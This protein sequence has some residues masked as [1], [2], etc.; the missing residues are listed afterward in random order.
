MKFKQ[1]IEWPIQADNNET[2]YFDLYFSRVEDKRYVVGVLGDVSEGTP[3]LRIESACIFGHVFQGVHC[4]CGTQW[5]Q[6]LERIID[7][8]KGI[9]IYS[10]DDDA[11]GHGIET[12]FDLYVLRQYEGM[13]DEEEIFEM[14]DEP[15][16]VRDYTPVVDTLQQFDVDAVELMTN[17]PERIA[18]L[19]D[20]GIEVANRIPLEAEITEHNYN[21]LLDEKEWMD[22]DTSYRT[23][24]EW[25]TVFRSECQGSRGYLLVAGQREIVAKGFG[26]ESTP[27]VENVPDDTFLTLYLTPSMPEQMVDQIASE[28]DDIIEV[29]LDPVTAPTG[30]D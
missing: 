24:D 15:M 4:D 28:V 22:Y 27:T 3:L 21:L 11:R 13:E 2:A 14:W 7:A 10:I 16:D 30:A 26:S 19:E 17:N 20:A 1:P 5:T 29:P 18:V 25:R 8:G 6:A 23:H 12:H 9:V